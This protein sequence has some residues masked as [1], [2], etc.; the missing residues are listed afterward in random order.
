MSQTKVKVSKLR[1][2]NRCPDQISTG[3]NTTVELDGQ[4]LGG[5]TFLKIELKPK[6]VAK[7]TIEMC[8]SLDDIELDAN[9]K[10]V[11]QKTPVKL[12]N[13]ISKYES[14]PILG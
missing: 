12:V 10:L 1:I 2:S 13:T 3:A 11:G 14:D 5:V 6:K 8:V 9:M 7:V 4:K